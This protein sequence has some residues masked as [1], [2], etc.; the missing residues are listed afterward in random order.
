M[1][2]VAL[3]I[4][5]ALMLSCQTG[6]QSVKTGL[7]VLKES[8]FEILKGK[9]VGLITNPTGVDNNMKSTIDILF[10][11][12]EV[13]L[14]ALFGPEH[15]VRGDAHAGDAVES[16]KDSRTGLP[17]YSLYGKT[18]K[19]TPE[20]LKGIDVLV[21]DIQDIG[22]RSFTY[23]SSMGLAMEAAAEN[24][25]E[26]VI[27]DRP[28]PLG[29]LKVEGS[30]T[31]EGFISFVSQFK[32]PY[33]Y[34]LTCG[35]LAVMLNE[36]G[37]IAKKCKL[38]VVPMKGWKRCMT[39]EKTGLQWVPASPHIPQPQTVMY[40][41]ATG[42]LGELYYISIGVGYTIPFQMFA[43][44]WIDA[45][46]LAERLNSY[47]LP[48]VAFR[49]LYVKPFY[50]TGSGMD[51][52]GVQ[53]H[54]LDYGKAALTDIQ[55]YVMQALAELYPEKAVFKNADPGRF[56]MF[57]QVT[58]SD[59]IRLRFSERHKFEDIKDYW[60]KDVQKFREMSGRYYLYK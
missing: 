1:K 25:V 47:K 48:G 19:A 14:V 20:M 52:Q 27:L 24:G 57:D 33:I 9:R 41:P 42:I 13:N 23:I 34:G 60:Y 17:V 37:M 29:G 6:A 21:Y 56:R 26:M 3:L 10:E 2:K 59:Q 50:S 15:G 35:E 43:S 28:N 46:T 58:G 7:E 11:A 32:I 44:E 51:Y 31:E 16:V 54:I 22:C 8:R 30:L 12:P 45:L 40:Y 39:Y 18:R 49:P 5:A 4:I 55:F 36:E 38:T 53:V